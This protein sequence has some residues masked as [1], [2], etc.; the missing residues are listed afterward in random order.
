MPNNFGWRGLLNGHSFVPLQ[1]TWEGL[2]ASS[3]FNNHE[4]F[5]VVFQP[6]FYEVEP[7]S[8]SEP[9]GASRVWIL[10]GEEAW[11][12]HLPL[13]PPS[14]LSS[15]EST[16]F[17]EYRV[18]SLRNNATVVSHPFPCGSLRGL[19]SP[20]RQILRSRALRLIAWP[21]ALCREW[22]YSVTSYKEFD[23]PHALVS[24]L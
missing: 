22:A 8:V 3:K 17:P 13:P 1:E 4:S 19:Q 2:L 20:M 16:A 18:C 15:T 24:H 21:K 14:P 23:F 11:A 10:D 6:F 12:A 7:P 5:T 9:C